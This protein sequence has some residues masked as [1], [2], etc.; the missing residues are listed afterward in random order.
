MQ[1]TNGKQALLVAS[2]DLL[3]HNLTKSMQTSPAPGQALPIHGAELEALCA[4]WRCLRSREGWQGAQLAEATPWCHGPCQPSKCRFTERMSDVPCYYHQ[5]KRVKQHQEKSPCSAGKSDS[6]HG[7]E[8]AAALHWDTRK[9]PPHRNSD[10]QEKF[11]YLLLVY[12]SLTLVY[13]AQWPLCMW[14][15][16]WQE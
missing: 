3:Y 7:H 13:L 5:Q 15:I 14:D 9:P 8:A 12:T 10:R 4:P 16:V 2:A 11:V 6:T 1:Y